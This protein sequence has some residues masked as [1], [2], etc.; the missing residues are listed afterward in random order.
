MNGFYGAIHF[1]PV[2]SNLMIQF[3]KFNKIV[4][5]LPACVFNL[6]LRHYFITVA[7]QQ[8]NLHEPPTVR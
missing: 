8:I 2:G 1:D 6:P 3:N 4:N 5:P 7:K